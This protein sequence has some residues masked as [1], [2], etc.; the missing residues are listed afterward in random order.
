MLE[1]RFFANA[2]NSPVEVAVRMPVN[3]Y[4]LHSLNK[5]VN[6]LLSQELVLANLF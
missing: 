3:V 5:K 6:C 2:H 4:G 1:M